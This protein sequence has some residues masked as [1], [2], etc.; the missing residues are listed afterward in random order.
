MDGY[1][2]QGRRA[3]QVT[4]NVRSSWMTREAKIGMLTGLGVIV[5]IGG[6]LSEDLGDS[7]GGKG[8]GGGAGAGSG[9]LVGETG[10]AGGGGGGG[11]GG[12]GSVS[13]GGATGRMA[14]LPAGSAYRRDVMEPVSVPVMIRDTTGDARLAGTGGELSSPIV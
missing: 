12:A 13:S 10:G 8:G 5:L 11:G 4:G 3:G 6:L 2:E 1:G 9:V 14:E 7:A